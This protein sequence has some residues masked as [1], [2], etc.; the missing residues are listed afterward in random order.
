MAELER[1]REIELRGLLLDGGD[2]RV[3][4]VAGVAAPQARGTVEN[5]APVGRVVVHVLRARDEA[6]P[7]L[8]GAVG[9]ERQPP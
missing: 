4:V 8:E 5:G 3:A 2:D 1:R 9:R 6:G 7:L